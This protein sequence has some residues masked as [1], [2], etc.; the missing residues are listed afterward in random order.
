MPFPPSLSTSALK[1]KICCSLKWSCFC[2]KILIRK[3]CVKPYRCIQL[4]HDPP[5]VGK[6]AGGFQKRDAKLL[7]LGVKLITIFIR[8]TSPFLTILIVRIFLF[9]MLTCHSIIKSTSSLMIHQ[10][11]TVNDHHQHLYPNSHLNIFSS[12]PQYPPHL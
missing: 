2:I 9:L 8:F 5:C 12:L 10:L 1:L 6:A 11:T 7:Y 3:N 4:P